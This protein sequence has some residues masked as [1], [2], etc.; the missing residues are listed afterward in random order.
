MANK[1]KKRDIHST[2]S[3]R[4]TA[5]PVT[6]LMLF[7]SLMLMIT[8]TYYVAMTRI[9]A[10]GQTLNFSVAKQIMTALENNIERIL[11]SPG[12]S[13]VCKIDDLGGR[14]RTDISA[15]PLTINITDNNFNDIIYESSVGEAAYELAYA[16]PG[17]SGSYLKG[18]IAAIVNSSSSTIAQ[19]KVTT[20]NTSQEIRL[21]YRPFASSTSTGLVG[22]KP[23]NALRIYLVKMVAFQNLTATGALN[24]KV[25]CANVESSMIRYNLSYPISSINIEAVFGDQSSAVSLPISSNSNGAVVDVELVTC[26]IQIRR[27][28]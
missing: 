5:L 26:I 4:A 9:T 20:G 17:V 21:S 22:D 18:S 1:E 10:K 16:E 27:V 19:L 24:L 6:F 3:R 23:V 13:F 7:V 8:T 25:T 12:S 14:F 15:R 2:R 11:W 28:G